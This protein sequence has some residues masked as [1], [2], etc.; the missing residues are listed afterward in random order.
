M[1]CGC[2]KGVCCS[3]GVSVWAMELPRRGLGIRVGLLGFP[4]WGLGCSWEL[5]RSKGT[6]GAQPW[7]MAPLRVQSCWCCTFPSLLHPPCRKTFCCFLLWSRC[8]SLGCTTPN[9]HSKELQTC[10]CDQPEMCHRKKPKLFIKKIFRENHSLES[11]FCFVCLYKVI[12]V[13]I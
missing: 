10:T 1:S 11:A 2:N 8:S 5:E 9:T 4:L 12:L 6:A 13:N 7:L 3:R